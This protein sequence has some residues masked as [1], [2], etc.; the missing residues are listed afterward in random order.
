MHPDDVFY[1]QSAMT[2]TTLFYATALQR[3]VSGSDQ[4]DF[5]HSM[6]RLKKLLLKTTRAL[7]KDIRTG[8][9]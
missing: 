3:L 7:L 2:G 9:S 6:E 8:R 1:F 5:R 4:Q